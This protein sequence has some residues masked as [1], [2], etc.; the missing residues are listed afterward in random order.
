[1]NRI[2]IDSDAL[3]LVLVTL[4]R[5]PG[6]YAHID[7]QTALELDEAQFFDT[8]SYRITPEARAW[9]ARII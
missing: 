9:L 2:S 1:M 7:P 3:V 6:M 5:E 4:D 8:D